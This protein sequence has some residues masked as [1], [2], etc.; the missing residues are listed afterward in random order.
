M[1][2]LAHR[3]DRAQLVAQ[4]LDLPRRVA[5]AVHTRCRQHVDLD[6]LI[7][8]GN[9]GLAEAAARFDPGAG[10]RFPAFASY[11]VRGAILD[12]LRRS[13]PLP[14]RAWQRLVALRGATDYLEHGAR[15]APGDV[16]QTLAALRAALASVRTVYL[17]SLAALAEHEQPRTEDATPDELDR[18]RLVRTVARAVAALPQRERMLVEKCYW[19]GKSLGTAAAEIGV[20][21]SWA[22]R[23]HAR[24]V[25]R[26]R[27][28]IETVAGPAAHAA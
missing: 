23:I 3:L 5:R 4:N 14:R 15:P 27:D 9:V 20:S 13:V 19:E 1:P 7:A 21:T 12:G 10:V 2:D 17:T 28:R 18:Q 16:A 11:R 22:S 26:L 8:L 24:A 6:E 25:E